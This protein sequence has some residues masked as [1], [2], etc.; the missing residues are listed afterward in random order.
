MLDHF[1]GEDVDVRF[2]GQCRAYIMIEPARIADIEQ[3][4]RENDIPYSIGDSTDPEKGTPEA[5]VIDFGRNADV[6]LIQS[7][8]DS[9]Q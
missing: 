2:D 5:A 7:V 9:I 1:T 6:A 8:I 3:A 4:L